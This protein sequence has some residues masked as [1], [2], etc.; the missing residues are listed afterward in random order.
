MQFA[1]VRHEALQAFSPSPLM[2][3]QISI[4]PTSTA[5]QRSPSQMKKPGSSRSPAFQII[6]T[7]DQT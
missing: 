7:A 5:S 3:C 6:E 2:A 4:Y 1:I